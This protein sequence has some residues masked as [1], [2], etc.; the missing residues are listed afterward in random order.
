[1]C[2]FTVSHDQKLGSRR[3]FGIG[4]RRGPAASETQLLP[5]SRPYH[6]RCRLPSQAGTK[7]VSEAWGATSRHRRLIAEETLSSY[8]PLWSE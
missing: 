7:R 3:G 2:E 5:S 4:G 8:G 1:M 6:P